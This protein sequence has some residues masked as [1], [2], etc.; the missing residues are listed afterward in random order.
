MKGDVEITYKEIIGAFLLAEVNAKKKKP[1]DKVVL[2]VVEMTDI[3]ELN[4]IRNLVI[5]DLP[6]HPMKGLSDA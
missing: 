6:E 4:E 5:I 1:I 3:D 2:R